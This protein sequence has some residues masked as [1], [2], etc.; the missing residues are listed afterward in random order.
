MN[1]FTTKRF[2]EIETA[3]AKGLDLEDFGDM[4]LPDTWL[5]LSFRALYKEFR[6]GTINK[7]TASKMK[8]RLSAQY[9]LAKFGECAGKWHIDRVNALSVLCTEAEK[10]GCEMCKKLVRAF[11]G[12]G[13]KG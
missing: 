12:R 5:Y 7:E 6:S 10:T 4:M 9:E 13:D 2:K 1:E 3:A 11:N 8:R